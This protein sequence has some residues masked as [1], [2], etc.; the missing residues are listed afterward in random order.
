MDLVGKVMS[1]LFNMM[2]N[3]YIFLYVHICYYFYYDTVGVY[4]F[5]LPWQNAY[6]LKD[7]TT[8]EIFSDSNRESVEI[9]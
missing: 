3:T 1:L 8:I 2:S 9:D 4:I 5:I 7:G 6:L